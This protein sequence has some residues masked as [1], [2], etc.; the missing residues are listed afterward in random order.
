MQRAIRQGRSKGMAHTRKCRRRRRK[1]RI[2]NRYFVEL[3]K[4]VCQVEYLSGYFMLRNAQIINEEYDGTPPKQVKAYITSGGYYLIHFD[5][6][7]RQVIAFNDTFFSLWQIDRACLYTLCCAM[8]HDAVL[9]PNKYTFRFQFKLNIFA[10]ISSDQ[11]QT[12]IFDFFAHSRVAVS[13]NQHSFPAKTGWEYGSKMAKK[14]HTH[15]QTKAHREL[16]ITRIHPYESSLINLFKWFHYSDWKHLILIW[17][18]Q[19]RWHRIRINHRLID[20]TMELPF[21]WK[22]HIALTIT[23][24]VRYLTWAFDS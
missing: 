12:N 4:Y 3:F 17:C 18:H 21:Q 1:R 7:I 14:A 15:R 20:A 6:L 22:S 24:Y 2:E 19:I 23:D 11:I 16:T 10:L 13:L 5:S 8:R 9:F